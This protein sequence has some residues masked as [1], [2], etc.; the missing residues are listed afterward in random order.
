MH[1]EV[2]SPHSYRPAWAKFFISL[3]FLNF[4]TGPAYAEESAVI[5][6]QE[7]SFLPASAA[8]PVAKTQPGVRQGA[9]KL[10]VRLIQAVEKIDVNE[11]SV[12]IR[13]DSRLEDLADKLKK[14]PFRNFNLLLSE[15]VRVPLMKKESIALIGDQVLH[16]RPL[17]CD[18]EK[19]GM[20]LKWSDRS[21]D[22]ILDT[23][24][25]FHPDQSMLVGTDLVNNPKNGLI[26]ALEVVEQ[27]K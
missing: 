25:H 14:L 4:I 5:D 26:L 16:L 13:I 19:I 11:N 9:V 20:W 1:K 7:S 2:F 22:E 24:M 8:Q 6:V 12:A 21:G 17:Y 3:F 18:Q 15:G 27:P 10:K 23:R